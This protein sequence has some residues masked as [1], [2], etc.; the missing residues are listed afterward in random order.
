MTNESFWCIVALLD[1]RESDDDAIIA[2]AITA[3]ARMDED[4]ICAFDDTLAT[5]L[6]ALDTREHAR[7]K[8]AGE[9]DVDNGDDY[10]SADDFLYG[11]CAVVA[12][13]RAFYEKVLADPRAMPTE[14][15][16][17]SLLY[18]ATQAFEKKT[19]REFDHASPLSY[20]SFSNVAGWKPLPE[21]RPGIFTGAG[22]PPGNRRPT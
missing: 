12:K 4:E 16:F 6:F 15:D 5:K 21:T 18:L 13:G 17:E 11:R 20:E 2:P 22:V 14:D 7:H 10:I 19:G 1:F 9:I 8:Y 3:L